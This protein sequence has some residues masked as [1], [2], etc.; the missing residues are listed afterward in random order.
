[1]ALKTGKELRDVVNPLKQQVAELEDTV[2]EVNEAKEELEDN[3]REQQHQMAR[4]TEEKQNLEKEIEGI[5][6][7]LAAAREAGSAAER[8]G[9][10]GGSPDAQLVA[11]PILPSGEKGRIV[12]VNPDWNFVVLDL[13]DEFLAELMGDDMSTFTPGVELMV[14]R[15]GM[16]DQFVT[17]VRL[18]QVKVDRNLGIA[19]ILPDWQQGPVHEGD[20][21]FY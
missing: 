18:M 9:P 11:M 5:E 14:K 4:M 13:S 19:D 17:K 7:Q 10:P 15:L 1:V 8:E 3:L 2:D 21:L 12:A 20:I 16:A 6:E